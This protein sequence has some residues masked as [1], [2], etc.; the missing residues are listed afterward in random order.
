ML[1]GFHDRNGG[2][3]ADLEGIEAHSGYNAAMIETRRGPSVVKEK[4]LTLSIP[5]IDENE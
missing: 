1:P 2:I 4:K 3:S 5:D